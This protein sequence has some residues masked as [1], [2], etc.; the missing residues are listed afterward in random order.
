LQTSEGKKSSG[1]KTKKKEKKGARGKREWIKTK[2]T[3]RMSF[4]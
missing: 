4:P 2:T 1:E 3:W